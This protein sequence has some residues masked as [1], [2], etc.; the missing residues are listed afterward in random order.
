MMSLLSLASS[1]E[2]YD[3]VMRELYSIAECLGTFRRF[4][5]VLFDSEN[6]RKKIYP[7]YK[8]HRNRKKPCGYKRVIQKLHDDFPCHQVA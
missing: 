6:F 5:P 8:G 1:A 7:D 2:A 3:M 4:T